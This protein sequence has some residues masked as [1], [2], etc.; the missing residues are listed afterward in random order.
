MEEERKQELHEKM[1][2]IAELIEKG[3]NKNQVSVENITFYQDFEFAQSGFEDHN[4]FVAKVQTL[5]D[6]IT[7]YE[8]YSEGSNSLIAT[9]NE[10]GKLHFMPEY[11]EK[12]R[13]DYG[14]HFASLKLEDSNFEL[15][16][17]DE[18]LSEEKDTLSINKE[19]IEQSKNKKTLEILKD[20]LG[21]EEVVSYTEMNSD[22][23]PL[24]DKITN[25]QELDANVRVTQTE[26]LSDMV[27]E[28]KEKGFVKIGV[29]YSNSKGGNC[30]RF[31]FLGVTKEGNIEPIESLQNIEGTTTGQKI[32]SI[33][34]SDGSI[35][36]TEQVAGLAKL[37]NGREEYFSV[38]QGQYGI[39]EVDYVRRQLSKGKDE[40]YFSAP[41]E[42]H[43]IKPTSKEVRELMDRHHNISMKDE[44][45]KS[46][47]E[48]E[49][50]GET[51]IENIDNTASNDMLGIDDIIVLDDGTETTIRNE[52]KKA[53][54]SP[55]E[56]LEK[57][58]CT[59]GKT[60]S[61]IIEKV[62]EEVEEEY[63]G[64][65]KR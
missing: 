60:P 40:S 6:S 1:L 48:L 10:H 62:H 49:R 61:E 58:E 22:Q 4:I 57:Y 59:G 50:D 55:E 8:I 20:T 26:S 5:K 36:E 43:S 34:S 28:I 30:G 14:E 18:S 56:F 63:A 7:T 15:P 42:T 65:R 39:I 12:L 35:I 41:I 47:P 13:E 23:T 38:K 33:N 54:I 3:T 2:S 25:K 16:E 64:N 51:R 9:V 29:A 24:F 32:T 45:D 37:P 19:G 27:P 31:T 11:I 52:A 21:D 17:N 53:K 44:L 46:K